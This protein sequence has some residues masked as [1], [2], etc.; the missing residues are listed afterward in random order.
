MVNSL[1][2]DGSRVML[3][4]AGTVKIH[5]RGSNVSGGSTARLLCA[6]DPELFDQTY[7]VDTTV[8][9]IQKNNFKRVALQFPDDIISDAPAIAYRLQAKLLERYNTKSEVVSSPSNNNNNEGNANAAAINPVSLYILGDTSYGS[10][11]V[12]EI[13]AEHVNSDF[14]VHYGRACLTP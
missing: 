14:I 1:Y 13:N 10:C 7:D 11:C 8:D 6:N 2:D 9:L 12:D 3:Q 4:E 5:S